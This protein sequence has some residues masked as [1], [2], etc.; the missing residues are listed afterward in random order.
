MLQKE[1]RI[2]NP[3]TGEVHVCQTHPMAAAFHEEKGYLFWARKSFAKSYLDID[4]PEDTT[5]KERGQLATLSKKIWSNTNM[6]GYRGNGG[7]R[8]YN[9][10]QIAEIIRLKPYQARAF[11][12]K[13]I[14]LGIM[15]RVIVETEKQKEI[16]YY[17]NPIYFFSNN[18]I[19]LNLYLIFKK[20]L[21]KY[22]E[23]WVQMEYLKQAKNR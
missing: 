21:D 13:M 19:P 14:K 22:I 2:F 16:Q 12:R 7:V 5:M 11:V 1:T 4:Y 3:D 8:P 10:D 20:Q 6:L 23:G 17:F 18:R 9:T 15:A